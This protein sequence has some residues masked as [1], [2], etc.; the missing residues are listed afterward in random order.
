[1]SHDSLEEFISADLLAVNLVD[2]AFNVL[3]LSEKVHYMA[4]AC[5]MFVNFETS[6]GTL[7]FTAYNEHNGYYGHAVIVIS[8]QLHHEG[9]L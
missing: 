9:V 4:E 8:E 7:Q 6:A 2:D 1:M 3:K 5:T